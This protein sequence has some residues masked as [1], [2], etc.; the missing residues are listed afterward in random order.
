MLD[1][2]DF[3][4]AAESEDINLN[5]I[6]IATSQDPTTSSGKFE[7][8]IA[9]LT[10]ESLPTYLKNSNALRRNAIRNRWRRWPNA[11]IP[12]TL[13]SRYGSYS[14]RTIA[15]AM[16]N[17]HENTCI[18]FVPRDADKHRDYIYIHP[19]DGCYSLVGRTG[20][21]QPLS[22][23]SGCILTGTI[24]HELMHSV[25]FFH[26]Q[27]RNDRDDWIRIVWDNVLSEA[28]DQFEKY[29]LRTITHLVSPH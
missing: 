10:V 29:S 9:G 27:S 21:R 3:K 24:I 11:Q 6:G 16:E 12:Y 18:R 2:E 5:S 13:S 25:G 26:E 19:D 17:Y 14:R 20:G 4:N 23:D 1:P 7:G 28:Q 22:L 8:D 15:K